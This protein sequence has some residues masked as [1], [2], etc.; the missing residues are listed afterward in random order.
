MTWEG[1]APAEPSESRA[2]KRLGGSLALPKKRES[3][4]YFPADAVAGCRECSLKKALTASVNC[5]LWNVLM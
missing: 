4:P 2:Q 5:G 3:D 1:E